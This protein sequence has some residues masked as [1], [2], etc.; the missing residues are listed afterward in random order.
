MANADI[1][2]PHSFVHSTPNHSDLRLVLHKFINT[3]SSSCFGF[4]D[5]N[6]QK[7]IA[8]LST[9]SP[10]RHTLPN[11]T[12]LPLAIVYLLDETLQIRVIPSNRVALR[13]LAQP[14]HRRGNDVTANY[15]KSADDEDEHDVE[16]VVGSVV[17][18]L[19]DLRVAHPS[20]VASRRGDEGVVSGVFV[21]G[22]KLPGKKSAG[23]MWTL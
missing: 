19:G 6:R 10:H 23:V 4:P 20:V 1:S 9:A 18:A 5:S 22:H 15:D 2:Q 14:I 21:A 13:P 8:L 7:W 11:R 17:A 3:P 12:L 16:D